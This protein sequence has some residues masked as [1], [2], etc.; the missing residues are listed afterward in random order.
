MLIQFPQALMESLSLQP[1]E[2][3]LPVQPAPFDH[4]LKAYRRKR[5]LAHRRSRRQ[6]MINRAKGKAYRYG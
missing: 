6:R 4:A 1:F 5:Q 3:A 2:E